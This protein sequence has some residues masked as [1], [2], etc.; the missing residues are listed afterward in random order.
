MSRLRHDFG[1]PS[2]AP[3]SGR[4]LGEGGGLLECLVQHVNVGI[5]VV[6]ADST[7]VV[8]NHFLEAHS[9]RKREDVVGLNLFEAF[10]D[11]PRAWLMRKIKHV[12]ILKHAAFTSW[13]QRPYLFRFAHHRMI[14]STLDYM[15]QDCTLFP[16]LN[17]QQEVTH[18]CIVVHDVTDVSLAHTELE[19]ARK[20]AESANQAKSDFL[21]TMSHEIRTPLGGV[22][23]M[24]RML[25][26]TE[27]TVEQRDLAQ[28]AG[29]CATALLSLLNDILDFSKIAA[30]K[31]ELEQVDFDLRSTTEEA[32]ELVAGAAH[33]K[34]LEVA[35]LFARDVPSRLNGD[36]GRL[37]QIVLNFLNNAVKFTARGSVVLHVEKAADL[38]SGPRV[39]LEVRDTGVGVP[40][41]RLDRLFKSFSQVDASTTRKYGGTGLGL[42]ICKQLAERMGGE[43]GVKSE[44]GVG[45]AFWCEIPL[46]Q[47]PPE[48]VQLDERPAVPARVLVVLPQ[49]TTRAALQASLEHL[50]TCVDAV[51]GPAD[52]LQLL[53]RVAQSRAAYRAC[54]VDADVLQAGE[55]GLS[56]TLEAARIKIVSVGVMGG[57]RHTDTATAGTAHLNRPIRLGQL[58]HCL[59]T[60]A[61]D[62]AA[63]QA[64]AVAQAKA[65]TPAAG[66]CVLIVEDNIVNQR[67]A[68]RMVEQLGFEVDLAVN[69]V[70]AIEATAR[71]EYTAVLM[72][73]EMPELDGFAATR[74]IRE[75]ERHGGRRVPIVAMTAS[76][77]AGDRERCVEAGM[78]EYVTKPITMERLRDVLLKTIQ[79]VGETSALRPAS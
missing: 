46:A 58:R 48:E 3:S 65:V 79:R 51:S 50:G 35:L 41:E 37:R 26:D 1:E 4:S 67:I 12:F 30:G 10:P 36:P 40:P 44:A 8:F 2:L 57:R 13:Q 39:R 22:I 62:D 25:L 6:D 42:V 78:D 55:C 68:V 38:P 28:T 24:N 33:Q 60:L 63:K 53:A 23:G 21:A 56:R 17:A 32:V 31:M 74:L 64:A 16:V 18:V 75:R 49:R 15:R 72:D 5:L 47:A 73:G 45:S 54:F 43:V 7:I 14:T 52:A 61:G 19:R 66:G 29:N 34:G 76:A 11:L 20:E 59:A 27:L 69:G 71:R 77:M 70:E 9:G